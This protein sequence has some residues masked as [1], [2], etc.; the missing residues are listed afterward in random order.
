[1]EFIAILIRGFFCLHL[2]DYD[3]FVQSKPKS[4]QISLVLLSDLI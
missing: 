3:F 2:T 4:P 1:M